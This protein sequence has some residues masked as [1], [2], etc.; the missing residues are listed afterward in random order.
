AI[1]VVFYLRT[2]RLLL[3]DRIVLAG[4]RLGALA[5]LVV[6][7]AGP[8]LLVATAVP[9]RNVIAVLVDASRSMGIEDEGGRT[10]LEAAMRE[11]A[12]GSGHVSQAL[13]ARFQV[14][15]FAFADDV[16]LLG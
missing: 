4:L 13:G 3:R 2:P 7:L 14:R 9:R 12:P 15:S 1:A 10:R 6:C 5:L 8:V 11:F 16:S